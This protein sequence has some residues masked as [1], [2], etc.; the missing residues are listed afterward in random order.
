MWVGFLGG[1]FEVGRGKLVRT[2]LKTSN[3]A[4]KYTQVNVVHLTVSI[5]EEW[6]YTLSAYLQ[7]L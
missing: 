4:R 1:G 7:T 3:L 2:K 5:K 6:T